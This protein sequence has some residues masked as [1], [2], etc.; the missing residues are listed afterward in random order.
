MKISCLKNFG[1]TLAEVL[2]S[3]AIIGVVAALTIPSL[4]QKYQEK[5]W[6]TGAKKF[7]SV[8]NQAVQMAVLEHG[9]PDQWGFTPEDSTPMLTYVMPYLKHAKFC[10]QDGT[11]IC[12]PGKLYRRNGIILDP[13]DIFNGDNSSEKRS[14]L[15]LGDGMIVGVMVMGAADCLSVR[16]TG[17]AA[18]LC[19]E[20]MVDIN[21][22]ASPNT[23][24]KDIF[25]FNLTKGGQIVPSGARDFTL[26][27]YTFE[28][29]CLS[30]TAEGWGCTGWVIENGNMDYWH[31]DDLSWDGK[32][33]CSD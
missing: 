2:I 29:G 13:V 16:G 14:G 8:M 33:K 26:E 11:D 25:I 6:V 20:Y 28:N 5:A 18:N 27:G 21:G 1:F 17:N 23:Y 32:H 24:G 7:Y 30:E 31:C 12:H 10:G 9:T 4:V 22:A 3:L 15:Q 19:G